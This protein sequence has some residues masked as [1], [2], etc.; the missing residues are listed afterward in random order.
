MYRFPYTDEFERSDDALWR[1]CYR[2]EWKFLMTWLPSLP[3]DQS[4]CSSWFHEP[5]G[6]DSSDILFRFVVSKDCIFHYEISKTIST[7]KRLIRNRIGMY[8]VMF[9]FFVTDTYDQELPK[10]PDYFWM[11]IGDLGE[12]LWETHKSK[13]IGALCDD[14]A[15]VVTVRATFAFL[16][17]ALWFTIEE[18]YETN[19]DLYDHGVNVVER[20]LEPRYTCGVVGKALFDQAVQG[21][22][23]CDLR[24]ETSSGYLYAH[25]CVLFQY[26]DYSQSESFRRLFSDEGTI[27]M[28][29]WPRSVIQVLF[30]LIYTGEIVFDKLVDTSEEYTW[31]A[32]YETPWLFLAFFAHMYELH[33][34]L[35][36]AARKVFKK[37]TIP[38][39]FA[40]YSKVLELKDYAILLYDMKL[41]P[42]ADR[43]IAALEFL[44]VDCQ[45]ISCS[46][47]RKDF[48]KHRIVINFCMDGCRRCSN[49]NTPKFTKKYEL[50]YS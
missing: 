26:S 29:Y 7:V 46:P 32:R 19:R 17:S 25:K 16:R 24:V 2:T 44:G 43:F 23:C 28:Q 31:W 49:K 22:S 9:E 10:T 14:P 47:E 6:G 34:I 11:N 40:P 35:E 48:V 41:F 15:K 37:L 42:I 13:R 5:T 33:T 36:F 30:S 45:D 8:R 39:K 27:L 18:R 4:I 21:N 1:H 12:R 38:Y 50:V 20:L 3:K